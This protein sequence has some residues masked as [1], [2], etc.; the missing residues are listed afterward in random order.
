VQGVPGAFAEHGKLTIPVLAM[1]G[2]Y[3]LGEYTAAGVSQ[4]AANLTSDVVPGAAHWVADE[5]PA[6]LADRLARFFANSE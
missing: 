3:S 2:Q 4:L 1:G 5:Q 6:W